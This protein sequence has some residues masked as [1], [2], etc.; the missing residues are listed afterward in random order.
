M[1]MPRTASL[2]DLRSLL[3]LGALAGLAAAPASAMPVVLGSKIG[4]DMS[5]CA[6]GKGPAIR[7]DVTGLKSSSGN[8]FVRTYY[9]RSSDW[10]KSKRY[11][12][13]IEVKPRQ[14]TTT[15]CIP[16]PSAGDY[17]ITVQHDA[18]GNRDT[19]FSTDGAGVSNNVRFGSFLGVIPRPPGVEKA[20]FSAG[21]GVTR[22]TIAVQYQ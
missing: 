18:N 22:M 1:S 8:L 2:P 16:L 14:G 13:R 12:H 19:D 7:L 9:A 21:S 3:A 17:A 5:L 10:L 6:A 15:V 20:R 4:N 11:I